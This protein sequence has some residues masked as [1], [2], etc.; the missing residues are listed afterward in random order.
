MPSAHPLRDAF[1]HEGDAGAPPRPCDAAWFGEIAPLPR[2]AARGGH[3]KHVFSRRALFAS[4]PRDRC[5]R[6][7]RFGSNV[8]SL[9]LAA[10]GM[11]RDRRHRRRRERARAAHPDLARPSLTRSTRFGALSE[12]RFANGFVNHH[13]RARRRRALLADRVG[14]NTPGTPG[15]R[16]R[17]GHSTPRRASRM[18]SYATKY[19][20]LNGHHDEV[21]S[22][23]V[24]GTRA[25]ERLP[26]SKSFG[27]RRRHAPRQGAAAEAPGRAPSR[28]RSPAVGS[29]TGGRAAAADAATARGRPAAVA[30]TLETR[31]KA[32]PCRSYEVIAS[33]R[34]PGTRPQPRASPTY[35]MPRRKAAVVHRQRRAEAAVEQRDL[36]CGAM[37]AR[38]GA[39]C[40]R[41]ADTHA[42][43]RRTHTHT[44][45]HTHTPTHPPHTHCVFSSKG[46]VAKRATTADAAARPQAAGHGHRGRC[47]ARGPHGPSP[48]APEDSGAGRATWS[49]RARVFWRDVDSNASHAPNHAS[50]KQNIADRYVALLGRDRRPV[51]DGPAAEG[52]RDER[53][54]A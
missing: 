44:H 15:A 27:H 8:C 51:A 53:P 16:A 2:A 47:P 9:V 35:R 29:F 1:V 40:A 46:C 12:R 30:R 38:Y 6:R 13:A 42:H 48:R 18:C 37:R 41:F 43:T 11:R 19:T 28:R 39:P 21:R 50:A 10:P 33:P 52:V 31:S 22:W 14:T 7:R 20:T 32:E 26:F 5:H 3:R 49:V 24:G 36:L 54:P 17:S 34:R 25:R 23:R 45:T 4:R